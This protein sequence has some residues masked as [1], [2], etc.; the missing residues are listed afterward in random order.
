MSHEVSHLFGLRHCVY[1]E[2]T[3]NGANGPFEAE[4]PRYGFCPI[5]LYKLKANIKFDTRERYQ[6][7]LKACEELGCE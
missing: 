6:A 3:M 5:C 4:R 2:C 1:Y 7:L